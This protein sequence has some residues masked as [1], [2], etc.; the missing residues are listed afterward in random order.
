M[1]SESKSEL[2]ENGS[3]AVNS[4]G[5]LIATY[6]DEMYQYS[7]LV[8]GLQEGENEIKLKLDAP[9]GLL[10]YIPILHTG[11]E[12]KNGDNG[13]QDTSIECNQSDC[14]DELN[15]AEIEANE[16]KQFVSEVEVKLLGCLY[17]IGLIG[18]LIMLIVM[19]LK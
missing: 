10:I 14:F 5:E 4:F 3:L 2:F 19:L 6:Q 15:E 12:F 16:Y 8:D 11:I 18:V 7:T 9:Y 13:G 1:I 17:R